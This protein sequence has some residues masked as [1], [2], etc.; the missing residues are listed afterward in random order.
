MFPYALLF[1]F[2]HQT[3]IPGRHRG[4]EK[5]DAAAAGGDQRTCE[6]AGRARTLPPAASIAGDGS[7]RGQGKGMPDAAVY[8]SRRGDRRARVAEGPERDH[9]EPA[10]RRK[11]TA[12]PAQP[13]P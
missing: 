12:S 10:T 3:A 5:A 13:N 2:Q 4:V 9:C 6:E 7:T 1:C 11:W 8:G